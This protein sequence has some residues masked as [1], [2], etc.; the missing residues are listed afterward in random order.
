MAISRRRLL[1]SAAW[2]ASSS[3]VAHAGII[4]GALPWH[5]NGGHPPSQV[6]PGPWQYFSL[7][8]ANAVEAIAD[9]LIPPDPTTP[10]GKDAGC[11]VFIDRQL[12]GPYGSNE[13]L[14]EQ[15]PF[16]KG[17][18]QQGPQSPDTPAT[19]Y[20]KALAALDKYCRGKFCDKGFSQLG[21]GDKD[22]FRQHVIEHMLQRTRQADGRCFETFRRI[23]VMAQK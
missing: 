8:E 9:R 5:P 18:K 3:L 2:L 16:Q 1:A 21:D 6:R 17:T 13:G 10:G 15:G 7:D 11:G 19:L 23:N 20:R 22:A 4:R 14:F 12:A